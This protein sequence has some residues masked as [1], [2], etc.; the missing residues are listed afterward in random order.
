ML[1]VVGLEL[2]VAVCITA[3]SNAVLHPLTLCGNGADNGLS[4]TGVTYVLQALRDAPASLQEVNLSG[5][6]P[7]L[8]ACSGGMC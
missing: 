7:T 4:A 5:A 3:L 2:Y 6:V 1:T 8:S